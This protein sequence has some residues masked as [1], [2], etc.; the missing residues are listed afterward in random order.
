MKASAWLSA[1]AV[2]G[3]MGMQP[4]VQ[5]HD[6]PDDAGSEAPIDEIE[7]QGERMLD[8]AV[9]SASLRQIIE[10][11]RMFDVVPL[12]TNQFCVQVI[13][14]E[15]EAS[16]LIED[17]I[18]LTAV[19]IG[20][21]RPKGD[22]RVNALVLVV[23]NPEEKFN[24]IHRHRTGLLGPIDYRDIHTRTLQQQLREGKPFVVWNQLDWRPRGLMMDVSGAG[25]MDLA[26]FP[27]A[28]NGREAG[29]FI[30]KRLSV[31]MFD[32]AQLKGVSLGQ[33]ADFASLYLLGLPRRQID[34]DNVAVSS[35]LSLFADGPQ[36][37][38][39]QMTEFDRAYLAG[40]YTMPRN[41]RRTGL[42]SAVVRAYEAQCAN[43][44]VACQIRLTK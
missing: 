43:P 28:L 21:K 22:C 10:P 5:A 37:A 1:C 4:A 3:L 23:D 19:D 8:K 2:L 15:P 16:R 14:L 7:V 26:A 13:G 40:L 6:M 9:L 36:S 24:L 44:D 12:F 35:V 25:W 34:F 39:A 18:T 27:D 32:H 11:I 30:P 33:L 42:H 20:L 31:I 17:R 38:P 29:R 41:S